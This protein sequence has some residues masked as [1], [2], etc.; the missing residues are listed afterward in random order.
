MSVAYLAKPEAVDSFDLF[1]QA[2]SFS[3]GNGA[4]L[5]L[6]E[7]HKFF[8]LAALNG[9][10]EAK[11]RRRELSEIMTENQISAAQRAARDWLNRASN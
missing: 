9:N 6:V 7:A 5:D 2:L 8:N 10:Q 3:T 11:L 4:E 1:N